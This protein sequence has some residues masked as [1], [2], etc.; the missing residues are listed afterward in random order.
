MTHRLLCQLDLDHSSHQ[1]YAMK[2]SQLLRDFKYLS[3][4]HN[5][6]ILNHIFVGLKEI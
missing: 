6:D 1:H 4:E 3:L 2:W 5:I